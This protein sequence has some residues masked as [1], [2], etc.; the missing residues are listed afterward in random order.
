MC[1]SL[2]EEKIIC[3]IL[4]SRVITS[5]SATIPR[6]NMKVVMPNMN[7]LGGEEVKPGFLL[8]DVYHKHA[9]SFFL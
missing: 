3:V 4:N 7:I 1:I 6:A 2:V 5:T 8:K 9:S